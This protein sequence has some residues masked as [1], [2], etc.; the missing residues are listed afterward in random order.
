MSADPVQEIYAV[1]LNIYFLQ[2]YMY[3]THYDSIHESKCKYGKQIQFWF[4]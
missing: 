2:N 3:L 1:Y 4:L